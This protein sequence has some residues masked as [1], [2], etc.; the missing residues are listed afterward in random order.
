MVR[1]YGRIMVS[2]YGRATVRAYGRIMVSRTGIRIYRY[3]HSTCKLQ[4]YGHV[5]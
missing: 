3:G 1:A 4:A 5:C 2:S